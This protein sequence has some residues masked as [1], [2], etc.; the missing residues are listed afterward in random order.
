MKYK[1]PLENIVFC[2]CDA[3]E[4]ADLS[5]DVSVELDKL[6]TAFKIT[7]VEEVTLGANLNVDKLDRL[8]WNNVEDNTLPRPESSRNP[9]QLGADRVVVLAPMQIRTFILDIVPK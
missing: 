7:S 4:D 8:K 3:D 1:Q 2:K 9:K 6:F 5:Q